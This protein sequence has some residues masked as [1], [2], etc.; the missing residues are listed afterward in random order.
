MLGG[1]ELPTVSDHEATTAAITSE[2]VNTVIT[3]LEANKSPVL[4]GY[5]AKWY[6]IHT[7]KP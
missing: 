2:E 1:I 7:E 5:T 3:R 6:K 4:H